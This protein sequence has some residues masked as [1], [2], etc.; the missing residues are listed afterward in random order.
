MRIRIHTALLIGLFLSPI[1]TASAVSATTT[2]GADMTVSL[3]ITPECVITSLPDMTF[4]STGVIS[5][6]ITTSVDLKVQCTNTTSYDIGLDAGAAAA[7]ANRQLG[8]TIDYNLYTDSG[9]TTVWGNTI[10]TD[11]VTSAGT[12]DEQTFTIYGL[13]PGPQTTPAPGSYTDTV[14]VTVTY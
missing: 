1:L 6:D 13:V 2:V 8:S 3:T 7:V 10:A 5:V 9:H 4:A 14:H 12:G 11:T